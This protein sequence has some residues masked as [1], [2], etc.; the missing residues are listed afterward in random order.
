MNPLYSWRLQNP[1]IKN[2]QIQQSEN[3][4]ILIYLGNNMGFRNK[5]PGREVAIAGVV[6]EVDFM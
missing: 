1:S 3:Q 2:G 4:D 6:W 5:H